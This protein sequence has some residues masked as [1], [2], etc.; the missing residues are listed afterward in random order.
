MVVKA[1]KLTVDQ[2]AVILAC[3]SQPMQDI[4]FIPGE[5]IKILAR[6]PLGG[7]VAVRVGVSTFA[8]RD[9]ELA[10]VEIRIA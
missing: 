5:S 10:T 8:V 7:P 4:G 2:Q 9:E 6:M 1:D 3:S